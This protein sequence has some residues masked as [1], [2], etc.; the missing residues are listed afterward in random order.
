MTTAS[1]TTAATPGRYPIFIFLK[2]SPF[3]S[4]KSARNNTRAILAISTG[5]IP[6][7]QL[8]DPLTAWARTRVRSITP[9][10]A[11]KNGTIRLL[12]FR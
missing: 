8:R 12:N 6:I 5:C 11:P 1:I 7:I 2:S 3:L 4:M 9:S 10:I